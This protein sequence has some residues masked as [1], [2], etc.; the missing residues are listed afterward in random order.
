MDR[1]FKLASG[2][3]AAVLALG[4]A[5]CATA[6]QQQV[7]Q[8]T[9]VRRSSTSY[10]H[11]NGEQAPVAPRAQAGVPAP[12]PVADVEGSPVRMRYGSHEWGVNY[13]LEGPKDAAGNDRTTGDRVGVALYNTLLDQPNSLP[14]VGWAVRDGSVPYHS[15]GEDFW[16][17]NPDGSGRNRPGWYSP[18]TWAVALPRLV[19]YTLR[20][21]AENFVDWAYRC[22]DCTGCKK[23]EDLE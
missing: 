9:P 2:L 4:G 8:Q 6:P 16:G 11:T 20:K 15:F 14:V 23:A 21:G 18:T 5:G 19:T 1:Q 13:M 12:A 3:V 17:V 22:G 10:F 7:Q